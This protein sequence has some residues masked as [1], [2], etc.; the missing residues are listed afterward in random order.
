MSIA[1]QIATPAPRTKARRTSSP[2]QPV[3]RRRPAYALGRIFA[4][5]TI[6]ALG[7]ALLAGTVAIGL[8]MLASNLAG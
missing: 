2:L 5:M 4:L 1:Q 8:I 6:T 3:P 7:A